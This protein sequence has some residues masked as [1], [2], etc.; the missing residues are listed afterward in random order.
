MT[1]AVVRPDGVWSDDGHLVFRVRGSDHLD[2]DDHGLDLIIEPD[3]QRRWKDVEDLHHQRTQGRID[4]NTVGGALAA[5]AEVSSPLDSN[6]HWW[7]AWDDWE[8]PASG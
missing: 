3:G 1:A 4:L 8:P 7:K 5:A 6:N 2:I